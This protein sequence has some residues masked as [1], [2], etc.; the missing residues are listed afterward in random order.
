VKKSQCWALPGAPTGTGEP[1][2][3]SPSPLSFPSRLAVMGW[4]ELLIS[5][6]F[7]S[8]KTSCR[9]PAVSKRL[10]LGQKAEHCAR[11]GAGLETS[12]YV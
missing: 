8:R 3:L 2:S 1:S 7:G 9:L 4:K 12:R 6:A 5:F 11:Q 10:K